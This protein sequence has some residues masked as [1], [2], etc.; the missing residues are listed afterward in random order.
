[1][2]RVPK[3]VG[4]VVAGMMAGAAFEAHAQPSPDL[5]EQHSEGE[6]ARI[7]NL[8][9]DLYVP[10]VN[11]A[12]ETTWSSVLGRV[13]EPVYIDVSRERS[14]PETV[15]FTV[16]YEYARFFDTGNPL[17]VEDY[18]AARAW[19]AQEVKQDLAN[20]ITALPWDKEHFERR[21]GF[22]EGA[23]LVV[24][25]ITV[26]GMTSP[27]ANGADTLAPGN[28]DDAN[29]ELGTHRAEDA[30]V[31]LREVLVAQGIDV[32]QAVSTIASEELQFAPNEMARLE[33]LAQA[34]GFG[35]GTDSV[36]RLI[37]RYNTDRITD[38]AVQEELDEIV[39]SK[40]KVEIEV[41]FKD[42]EKDHV[43]IPLPLLA[44]FLLRRRGKDS[45][46]TPVTPTEKRPEIWKTTPD[47][48]KDPRDY[49]LD[50]E[51]DLTKNFNY[52]QPLVD[53]RIAQNDWDLNEMTHDILEA[54]NATDNPRR[55]ASGQA[56]L[57]HKNNP[58]QVFYAYMHAVALRELTKEAQAKAPNTPLSE[59][60]KDS[61]VRSRV[62]AAMI[63][64]AEYLAKINKKKLP[65]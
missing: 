58:R 42:G 31:R 9:L 12:G 60:W 61:A 17:S 39:G 14:K 55:R 48:M 26:V 6:A 32:S 36:Y 38:P 64:E 28:I 43:L 7:G 46:P 25:Q 24:D 3:V 41:T 65:Q 37:S 56:E 15:T 45:A 18:D 16:P 50:V 22:Q 35:S 57:D 10:L 40:R 33:A 62:A 63:K 54:W 59:A 27:E 34:Q 2:R 4:G 51:V 20:S 19:M 8:D 49:A 1:M 13:L 29:T 44:L 21:T 47:T 30:E 5:H 23:S 52:Y 11:P 53:P